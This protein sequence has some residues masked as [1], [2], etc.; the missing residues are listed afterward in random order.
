[1]G[2]TCVQ[3]GEHGECPVE[4]DS[5]VQSVKLGDTPRLFRGGI[6]TR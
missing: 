2:I 4:L 5:C 3:I 1:M 6:T